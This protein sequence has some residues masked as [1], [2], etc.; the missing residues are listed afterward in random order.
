VAGDLAEDL[1]VDLAGM[2]AGHAVARAVVGA[3]RLAT[4]DG[5]APVRPAEL[6]AARTVEMTAAMTGPAIATEDVEPAVLRGPSPT[7]ETHRWP[8]RGVPSRLSPGCRTTFVPPTS[9]GPCGPN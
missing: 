4:A 2:P 5:D 3:V 6:T 9:T 8:A 1:L 7:G